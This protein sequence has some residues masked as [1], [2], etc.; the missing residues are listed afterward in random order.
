MPGARVR[1]AARGTGG[2]KPNFYGFISLLY[3]FTASYG[4]KKLK[5]KVRIKR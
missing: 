3:G 4:L 2:S 5:I 1:R